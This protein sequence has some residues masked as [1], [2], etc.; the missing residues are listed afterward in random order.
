MEPLLALARVL[1]RQAASEVY[2]YPERYSR[3][4]KAEMNDA[5][6]IA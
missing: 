2:H 6:I 1:G 5:T 4:R 3:G